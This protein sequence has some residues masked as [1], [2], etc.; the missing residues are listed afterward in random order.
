MSDLMMWFAI[1]IVVYIM[2]QG[3]NGKPIIP[4]LSKKK[5]KTPAKLKDDKAIKEIQGSFTDM[6]GIKAM[7]SELVE[8][9]PQNNVRT[10]VGAIHCGPINYA[11][12]SN[13]E[14]KST[15][16]SL[17]KLFASL[18][19]GPG[20]EVKVAYHVQSRPIELVDQIKEYQDALPN[21][22]P[23][24]Q[25]FAKSLF[26]PFLQSWQMSVEE[27]DYERYFL[28]ILEYS[29]NDTAD[30]DDDQIIL[31]S[32]NEYLRLSNT[33]ITNYGHMGGLAK[34]CNEEK[35]YEAMYFAVR[36]KTG[37]IKEFRSLIKASVGVTP[38]VTSNFSR[39][40]L[41]VTES[42]VEHNEKA[43]G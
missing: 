30:L 26:F 15:D 33:I 5:K 28:V 25:R 21:H 6:L 35:L 13:E 8:L 16:D 22:T 3:I 27:Y 17:E 42:E 37:H 11:L 24:V 1:G 7:H 36:K 4:F 20:R 32:S 31:K 9:K 41:R 10:F 39:T 29:E 14:R 23:V 34:V 2:Y 12:R 38:I 18:S 40:S 43:A 19:L